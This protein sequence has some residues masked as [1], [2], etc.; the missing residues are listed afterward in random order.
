MYGRYAHRQPYAWFRSGTAAVALVYLRPDADAA[1]SG[2]TDQSGSASNLYQAID[3]T[4]FSDADYIRSS[5][6]PTADIVRF[7]LSDPTST[8]GAPFKVSYRYGATAAGALTIT[9]RLKQGATVIK[10][11][12]HTDAST[13][14]KTVSQTLSSGELASITDFNNLFMEFEAGP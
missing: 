1:N 7:R 6:N 2:W 5:A 9:A 3:E 10:S 13:T 4:A 11:W 14:F 12:V 8:P